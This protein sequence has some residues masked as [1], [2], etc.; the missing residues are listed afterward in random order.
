[1]R[2]NMENPTAANIDRNMIFEDDEWV[3]Y[4]GRL[5]KNSRIY[6]DNTIQGQ[7]QIYEMKRAINKNTT[8][9]QANSD[10]WFFD[11]ITKQPSPYVYMY[12]FVSDTSP[13]YTWLNNQGNTVLAD[14]STGY[15]TAE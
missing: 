4:Y 11:R 13:S 9:P 12:G 8:K 1:M 15:I 14:T 10:Q 6:E 2:P 3:I 7:E 5:C